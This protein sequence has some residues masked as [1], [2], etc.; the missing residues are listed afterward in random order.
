MLLQTGTNVALV[1]A[2]LVVV[3][4]VAA[5]GAVAYWV[6]R[7]ADAR[8][9]DS[10]GWWALAVAFFAPALLVYVFRRDAIGERPPESG[11]ERRV[12]VVGTS[13]LLAWLVVAVVSPPDP[14]TQMLAA[15]VVVPLAALA[16]YLYARRGPSERPN[17]TT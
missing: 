10:P 5:V 1:A 17:A 13:V 7:D 11:R 8:G 15:G 4:L 12:R 16:G 2:G 9:S 3:A 6:Y 14:V